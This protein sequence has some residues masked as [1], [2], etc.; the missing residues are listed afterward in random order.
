VPF[1]H[2][3]E[4]ID[5]GQVPT[6]DKL[7]AVLQQKT[8]A[9]AFTLTAYAGLDA[10]SSPREARRL[11]LSRALTMRDY[12][13][14][15]GVSSARIDV[16]ALGANVPSGDAD[17]VD[18]KGELTPAPRRNSAMQFLLLAHERQDPDAPQRRQRAREDHLRNMSR[19]KASGNFL[20]GGALLDDK[21]K[22]DR[23][24][25]HI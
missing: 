12:L 9:Y 13:T 5:P 24:D 18:I 25:Y 10:A 14:T 22:H 16:R 19:L 23:L 15:K 1:T 17:R 6:L 2:G 8:A 7:V 21:W 20:Y 11:S 3:S 4:N